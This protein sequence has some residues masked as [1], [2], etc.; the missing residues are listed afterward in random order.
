[1][2]K[3]DTMVMNNRFSGT[4]YV[5]VKG[6][7][8]GKD[9]VFVNI[10]ASCNAVLRHALW[11]KLVDRKGKCGGAVWCIGGDFNYV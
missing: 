2:W 6:R 1:M 3:K 11:N 8:K 5:G 10:Y 9:F 7:W 4:G